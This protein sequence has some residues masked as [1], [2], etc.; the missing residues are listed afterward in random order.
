MSNH[1]HC[2]I[3]VVSDG[4]LNLKS[5]DRDYLLYFTKFKLPK[6]KLALEGGKGV[7]GKG[8]RQ[9]KVDDLLSDFKF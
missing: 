6:R 2:D 8:K 4:S 9:R 3:S 5:Y 1:Y 7:E